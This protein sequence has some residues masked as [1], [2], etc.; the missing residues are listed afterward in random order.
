[1]LPSS[2]E[3]VRG[4]GDYLSLMRHDIQQLAAA[5]S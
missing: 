1:V 5:V 3:G 2:V 4:V